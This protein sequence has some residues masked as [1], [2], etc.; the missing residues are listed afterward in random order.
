MRIG[1]IGTGMLG[2]AVGLHLLDSGFELTVYNRTTEKTKQLESKGAIVVDSPKKVAEELR[3]CNN[4]C[5][6]RR[7]S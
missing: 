3:T 1:I 7:R 6:R 2:N 5:K 4:Y